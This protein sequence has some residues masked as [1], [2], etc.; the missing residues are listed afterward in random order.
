MVR[1]H[2]LVVWKECDEFR[3][4]LRTRIGWH[5]AEEAAVLGHWHH[6]AHW[7]HHCARRERVQSTFHGGDQSPHLQ[8]LSNCRIIEDQHRFLLCV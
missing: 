6:H 7:L 5:A 3:A 4:E 8:E 1:W 2:T